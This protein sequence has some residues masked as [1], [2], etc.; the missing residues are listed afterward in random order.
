MRYSQVSVMTSRSQNV[1][2][3]GGRVRG[4]WVGLGCDVRAYQ[5]GECA[6]GEELYLWL[7]VLREI[8]TEDR[9][10]HIHGRR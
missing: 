7:M 9:D 1:I 6:D 10:Q 5:I 3:K 8:W 4:R 2:C